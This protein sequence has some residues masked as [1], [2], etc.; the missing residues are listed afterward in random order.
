MVFFGGGGD[1]QMEH[2]R[3]KAQVQIKAAKNQ[4]RKAGSDDI[5]PAGFD[6]YSEAE[7]E[8]GRRRYEQ[9]NP[10]R[11]RWLFKLRKRINKRS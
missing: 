8:K 4:Y 2:E 9:E 11:F 1:L 10:S 7:V 5:N 6:G 3:N